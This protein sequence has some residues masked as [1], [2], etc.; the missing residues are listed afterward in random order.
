MKGYLC[1][2]TY[3]SNYNKA[4]DIAA[5]IAVGILGGM[6]DRDAEKI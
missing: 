3:N 1:T 6:R 2:Q 4:V 5:T